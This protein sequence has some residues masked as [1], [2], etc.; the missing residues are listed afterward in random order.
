MALSLGILI[1]PIALLLILYRV[2]F[3]GDA[4][5]TV[6]AAPYIQEA[7]QAKVFTVAVPTGLGSDWKTTT[8]NYTGAPTG[9]TLRIGYIEPG[10]D[11]IQLV[12]SSVPTATLLRTELTDKAAPLMTSYRAANGVWRLYSAR[13][14]E[15]ALVLTDENRTIVVVGKADDSSLEKLAGSLS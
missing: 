5:V 3:N 11:P 10:G 4:P 7:Q 8:A 2:F 12:E 9:A 6:D 15:K 13:L 1:V 14:G